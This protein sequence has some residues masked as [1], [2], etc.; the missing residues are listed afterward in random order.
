MIKTGRRNMHKIGT[1]KPP[2]KIPD[3]MTTTPMNKSGFIVGPDRPWTG[4]RSVNIMRA[5]YR[6]NPN[7]KI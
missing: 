3:K 2:N 1:I 4:I 7:G 5:L 6:K